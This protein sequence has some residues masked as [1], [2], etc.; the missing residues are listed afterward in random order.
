MG[1]ACDPGPVRV[2]VLGGTR[3][4]GRRIVARLAGRGDAVLVVHRGESEPSGPADGSHLHADRQQL[5]RHRA[6]IRAFG[7]DAVVDTYALTAAD[8]DAVLPVLPDVPTVV[9]SSQDVYEA[10]NGLHAG[11]AVAAVPLTEDAQ[12]R[13][14]RYPYRGAGLPQVPDDYDKLDVEARWLPRGAVVLRLPMV[15]GPYD[16]QAR[17]DVV[18]RRVR[19]GRNR[20]PIGSG[21]LLWSRAHVDDVASAVLSALDTRAADG[22]AV[23]IGETPTATMGAW[24]AQI[25]AAAGAALELVRVQDDVLPPDLALFGAPVQHLLADVRLA[26]ELLGWAA[27]ERVAESVAWHLAHPPWGGFDAAADERA[28]A[29][30]DR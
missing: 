24:A 25:V 1:S 7:A 9:L 11:R 19:A 27:R 22:R 3:F 15:Y 28:L 21:G 26:A 20:M 5:A 12:L 23:N 29:T 18:L 17:E 30:A 2:L 8:V 6:R 13:R 10:V 16:G 14:N 4:I